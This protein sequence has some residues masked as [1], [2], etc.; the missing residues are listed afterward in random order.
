[1][2]ARRC[3][4]FISSQGFGVEWLVVFWAF[5][6]GLDFM[7][8]SPCWIQ[9]G[10]APLAKT[11]QSP[12]RG[13]AVLLCRTVL[14]LKAHCGHCVSTGPEVLAREIPLFATQA[15]HRYGALPFLLWPPVPGGCATL[16]LLQRFRNQRILAAI[17]V[18]TIRLGS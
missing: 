15:G 9:H 6:S 13:R 11:T 3:L 2:V 12:Q 1:I 4:R 16:K 17:I 5:S 7:L 14:Q 8:R 18:R 10:S